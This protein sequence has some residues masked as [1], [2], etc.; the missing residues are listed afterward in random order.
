MGFVDAAVPTSED[1]LF[2][3]PSLPKEDM[4]LALSEESMFAA[5]AVAVVATLAFF[6]VVVSSVLEESE[7]VVFEVSVLEGLDSVLEVVVEPE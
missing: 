5:V 7:F 2:K 6:A 3:S 1:R 4:S